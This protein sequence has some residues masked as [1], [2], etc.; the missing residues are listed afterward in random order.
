MLYPSILTGC[1]HAPTYPTLSANDTPLGADIAFH[2]CV[3]IFRVG[4][5]A[6]F[7]ISF[8][9]CDVI[10]F[11]LAAWK[12]F[13]YFLESLPKYRRRKNISDILLR[14]SV[15]YFTMFVADLYE[16]HCNWPDS[17]AEF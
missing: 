16:V 17:F 7:W 12:G 8:F 1:S 4:L 15:L 10:F 14:D 5:A 2:E 3:T 6:G 11:S 13:Q 9:V